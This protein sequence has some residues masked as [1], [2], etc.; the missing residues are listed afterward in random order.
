MTLVFTVIF[1]KVAGI[2]TDGLP[3]VLFYMC[4]QLGWNYF[5]QTLNGNASTLVSNAGLFGKVYFPRLVVPLA[6]LISN[7]LAFGI[8]LAT[9]LAFL[10]YFK[11]SSSAASFGPGWQVVLFPLLLLQTAALSLGVGLIM[12]ALTAKYRDLTHINTL[13]IQVWMYATPVIYP[14]SKF[15]DRWRWV[16]A[17]NPMTPIVESYRL[18]FLGVGTVEVTH[19]VWSVT[20][21]VFLVV[22]GL[23]LFGKVERTFV[24]IV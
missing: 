15:P 4:G 23:L 1:A 20:C 10:A 18:V 16:A 7:V 2:S 3:P 5:A 6:G 9:F 11:Y 17:L 14:L 12:S 19:V 8:Q 13:L 22:G 21:A 24:D